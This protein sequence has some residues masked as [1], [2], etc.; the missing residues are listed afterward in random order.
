MKVRLN[1]HHFIFFSVEN[2]WKKLVWTEYNKVGSLW[3]LGFSPFLYFFSKHSSAINS[4][5]YYGTQR[6]NWMKNSF[7]YEKFLSL[8]ST[9]QG[10][11][12][13]LYRAQLWRN[14]VLLIQLLKLNI[15]QLLEAYFLKHQVILCENFRFEDFLWPSK[16]LTWASLCWMVRIR[17]LEL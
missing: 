13:R 14:L 4:R 8:L 15:C 5:R 3:G 12:K 7:F 2:G 10:S 11:P 6:M 9:T 17:Y 16:I 1:L